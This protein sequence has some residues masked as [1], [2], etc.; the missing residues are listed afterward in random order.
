MIVSVIVHP[1]SKLTRVERDLLDTVHVYVVSPPL[2]GK[3]NKEAVDV[4]ASFF[5]V[6]SNQVFLVGGHKSKTK[7][8]EILK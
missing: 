1:N 3:A 8:F 5:G 6:K 2:E 7:K 4:L